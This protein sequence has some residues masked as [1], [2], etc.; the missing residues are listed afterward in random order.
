MSQ[1]PTK[2]KLYR[3]RRDVCERRCLAPVIVGSG[4]REPSQNSQM[5]IN[6]SRL[7]GVRAVPVERVF[8]ITA[9]RWKAEGWECL[10][11][12]RQSMCERG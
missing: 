3:P 2:R 12:E 8:A 4:E 9:N 11:D 1:N 7:G 6:C 10:Q 5:T